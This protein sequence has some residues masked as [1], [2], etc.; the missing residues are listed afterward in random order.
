MNQL[1]N[2]QHLR[3]AGLL[4][5]LVAVGVASRYWW[6]DLPNFKPVAALAL[7]AGFYFRSWRWGAACA[8]LI[9]VLSDGWLGSYDWPIALSVAGSMI[10]AGG[11]GG[12]FSRHFPRQPLTLRDW[13][14]QVAG[15]TGLSL[16]MATFFFLVT[17]FAVWLC[18]Y[19]PSF[20]G[21]VDCYAAALPFFRWTLGGDLL[22]TFGVMGLFHATQLAFAAG[23]DALGGE[24]VQPH[25][26][27]R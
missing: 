14:R 23:S 27:A 17:N 2:R 20:A 5:I 6:I 19:P 25:T 12:W 26:A 21:L 1:L 4:L 16:I 8:G 22:F 10:A 7:F 9:L 3:S 24:A 18:W 15:W 11:L 13:G